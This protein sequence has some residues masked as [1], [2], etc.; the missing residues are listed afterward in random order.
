MKIRTAAELKIQSLFHYQSFERPERLERILN[1]GTIYL[2]N[3]KDFNDPWDCRPWFNKLA[4]DDPREY[5]RTVQWF[6]RCGRAHNG[7]MSEAERLRRQIEMRENRQLVERMIDL[8]S[9]EMESAIYSQYR[10]FCLTIHP[11]STLMWSHYARAHTGVCLEFS[12]DNVLFCGALPVEYLDSYP[13]FQICDEDLDANLRPLLTKSAVW[14][15]EHEFRL[16]ATELP[17]RFPDVPAATQGFVALPKGALKAVI[18]GCQMPAEH[19]ARV[20]SLVRSSGPK[21][22]VKAAALL[23]DRYALEIQEA[24]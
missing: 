13:V 10:V 24:E 2:S 20:R 15:C 8:S 6:V 23:R 11:D 17:I 7:G 1:E 3:P 9:K 22:A 21:V 5:E 12:V 18:L 16:V 19:R 4:L 14:R